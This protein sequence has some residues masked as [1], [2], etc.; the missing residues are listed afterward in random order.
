MAHS[1]GT[2]APHTAE[3]A[4]TTGSK[5]A[6]RARPSATA[7]PGLENRRDEDASS[8]R[9]SGAMSNVTAESEGSAATPVV[10]SDSNDGATR[11]EDVEYHHTVPSTREEDGPYNRSASSMRPRNQS[12]EAHSV[13][14]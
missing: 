6:P 3:R 12:G 7:S 8:N 2:D 5:D 14:E 10:T 9:P 11:T 13:A 1:A 4:S